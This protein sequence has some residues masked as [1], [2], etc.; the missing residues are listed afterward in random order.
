MIK[1][2]KR[3]I[4]ARRE[5]TRRFLVSGE[6]TLEVRDDEAQIEVVTAE[7]PTSPLKMQT[8]VVPPVIATTTISFPSKTDIV[9]KYTLNSQQRYAFMIITGHLDGD[10]Q[11]YMSMQF[12][13]FA[14]LCL[15][16]IMNL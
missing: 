8:V 6:G 7:I 3:D 5:N 13:E 15:Q 14:L 2:W 12:I 16:L 1:E 11:L 9:K 4:E 10:N